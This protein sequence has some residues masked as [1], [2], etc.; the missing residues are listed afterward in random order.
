MINYSYNLIV[1][2]VHHDGVIPAALVVASLN[3]LV[4]ILF[5]L[6]FGADQSTMNIM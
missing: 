1:W 4:Q 3:M 2:L 5:S 6:L